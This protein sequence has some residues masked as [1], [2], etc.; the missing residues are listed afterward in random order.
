MLKLNNLLESIRADET[1]DPNKKED[2]NETVN[3]SN[4]EK[5]E[6]EILIERKQNELKTKASR[7]WDILRE[8]VVSAKDVSSTFK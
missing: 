5:T 6:L 4:T 8:S 2:K 3:K 7:H 1:P